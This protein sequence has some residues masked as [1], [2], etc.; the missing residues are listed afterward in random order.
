MGHSCVALAKAF[1]ELELVVQE[2]P[3][4]LEA[5]IKMVRD[6][7]EAAIAHRIR[8]QGYDFFTPQPVKGAAV[9]L[10]RQILH[11]WDSESAVKILKNTVDSMSQSSHLLIMDFVLPEPGSILSI[12]ERELRSKDVG[13]MQRFNAQ[14]RD[15][16]E[17]RTIL[18]AADPRLKIVAV[19]KP[20]GSSMS[21]IDAVRG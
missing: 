7:N 15:L 14:E 12:T 2:I 9:Y 13:M 20:Y 21:V 6:E 10:F 3:H 16:Q 4:V 1:P 11:N 5:G 8:F 17:W 19:N 18:E